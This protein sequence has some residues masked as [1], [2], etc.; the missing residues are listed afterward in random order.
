[1]K[2]NRFYREGTALMFNGISVF[3]YKEKRT[4]EGAC[5]QL[6]DSIAKEKTPKGV[7]LEGLLFSIHVGTKY[8]DVVGYGEKSD[9]VLD[10]EII[11]ALDIARETIR[12]KIFGKLK[13]DRKEKE[14]IEWNKLR[15]KRALVEEQQLVDDFNNKYK[16]GDKVQIEMKEA[17][18][19][20]VFIIF[21]LAHVDYHKEPVIDVNEGTSLILSFIKKITK[22]ENEK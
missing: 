12:G 22:I 18:S 4:A 19:P 2:K 21:K 16:I 17:E 7:N 6:N 20:F 10:F 11:G 5:K 14:Q 15:T 3:T 1:M 13:K 8:V 9:K